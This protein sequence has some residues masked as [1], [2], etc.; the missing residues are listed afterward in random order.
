MFRRLLLFVTILSLIA[1]PAHAQLV[2]FDP[3]N[4]VQTTLIAYR[5]QQHYAEL[6]AQYLTILRMGQGLG[7][8]N[9]YR[10][11]TIPIT[12]HDPGR[13]DFCRTWI[14]GLNS[15]GARGGRRL[16]GDAAP[17]PPP[18]APAAYA[19]RCRQACHG[20]P[21]RNHR[22]HRFGGDDGRPSG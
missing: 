20:A 12:A 1:A 8:L 14:Q 18:Y 9:P 3:G 19:H 11:P 4:L 2:V 15:G 5:M 6:R 21:I 17:A 22:N 16:G 13:W 7:N 10:I